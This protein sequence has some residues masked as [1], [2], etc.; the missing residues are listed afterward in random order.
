MT[1]GDP[2]VTGSLATGATERVRR[3]PKVFINYRGDEQSGYALLLDRELS[4]RHGADVVFRASR[5][6]RPGDQFDQQI[7]ASLRQCTVLLAVIGR[8]WLALGRAAARR[9][10]DDWVHRE[11]AAAFTLGIRVIPI[12][13]EGAGMPTKAELPGD[14]DKLAACQYLRLHHR[15]GDRDIERVV[16][17]IADLVPEL[18]DSGA[19]AGA[20]HMAARSGQT[21][22]GPP[23]PSTPAGPEAGSAADRAVDAAKTRRRPITMIAGVAGAAALV[24]LAAVII[25]LNPSRREAV[26][27]PSPSGSSSATSDADP[28]SVTVIPNTGALGIPVQ[29]SGNGFRPGSRVGLFFYAAGGAEACDSSIF[30][31]D[32]GGYLRQAVSVDSQGSFGPVTVALPRDVDQKTTGPFFVC[33]AG[34]DRGRYAAEPYVVRS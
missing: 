28:A 16:E 23:E 18:G 29:I 9:G 3:M 30:G 22:T 24:A 21:S 15:D 34:L 1:G 11:I 27:P 20:G 2:Y 7:P 8:R 26:G 4:R 31:P 25:I 19:A 32:K 12:L 17:A 10:R 14:I 33:A 5:S 6:I 13:V